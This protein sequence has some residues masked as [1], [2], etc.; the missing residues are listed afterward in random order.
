MPAALTFPFSACLAAPSLLHHPA[1]C[2]SQIKPQTRPMSAHCLT[3]KGYFLFSK[4]VVSHT[5]TLD[6][7]DP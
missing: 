3:N 7:L 4:N 2:T 6:P 5:L 1:L